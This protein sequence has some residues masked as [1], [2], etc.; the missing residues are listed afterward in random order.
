MPGVFHISEMV[1]L[2]LHSMVFITIENKELVSVKDIA[3]KTNFSEA[4]LSKVLQRLV[5]AGFLRSVR[6]PK[7][8]FGLL[9][10]PED[11]NLLEIFE[12]IEGS[13]TIAGCPTNNI[14]CPFNQCIFQGIPEKLNNQFVEFL[15]DKKLSDFMKELN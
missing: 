14:T 6:G 7:G 9:K 11:I 4:H 10:D 1:S 2:A 8:G 5:K 3:R 13:I 15:Q 12:S